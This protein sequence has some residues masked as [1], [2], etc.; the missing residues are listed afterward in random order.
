MKS[1]V[2]FALQER[3]AKVKELRSRLEDMKRIINW[4]AFLGM[5][6]EKGTTRGRPEYE[7][8]LMLK[9][10]FLQSW[11][12][13]S[14][15]EMEYQIYDRLSFQQFLDFPESI[16]DYSTIWRFRDELTGGE[17]IDK[18]WAELKRQIQEKNI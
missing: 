3:Y 8:I 1:L 9:I 12:S 5:F 7:K 14:D 16:P 15:E 13:I 2:D 10:L 18:I 4:D 6:P 11:Y 17:T